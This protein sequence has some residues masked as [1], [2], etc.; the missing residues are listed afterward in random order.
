M[1]LTTSGTA[2]P[3]APPADQTVQPSSSSSGGIDFNAI[4]SG[5]ASPNASV[6]APNSPSIAGYSSIA[7][8]G[9]A[10]SAYQYQSYVANTAV[11]PGQVVAELLG[12]DPNKVYSGDQI[13]QA[14]EEAPHANL[15]QLQQYL[16]SAGMYASAA[17]TPTGTR[18]IFGQLNVDSFDAMS[19]LILQ[20]HNAAS[21]LS[22]S[23]VGKTI[24]ANTATMSDYIN[25]Q[26]NSGAGLLSIQGSL[27]PVP[28]GGNTYQVNLS[29]PN[30]IYQTAY[31][32]FEA[33]LGRAPTKTELDRLTTTLHTQETSYQQ[34]INTQAEN[35][36]QAKY[37][38]QIA[39]RQAEMTPVT[40]S[41]AI[42]NGPVNNPSDYAISL[43]SY[44]FGTRGVTASNVAM[45][46]SW[47]MA[48]GGLNAGGGMNPLGVKTNTPD[49]ATPNFT[50]WAQSIQAT[51]DLLSSPQYQ[52]I[53]DALNSGDASNQTG[54]VPFQQSVAQ[55]S[56][57]KVTGLTV[58]KAQTTAA[59]KAVKSYQT[60]NA[61]APAAS[62][63][64]ATGDLS[65]TA[66]PNYMGPLPGTSTTDLTRTQAPGYMGPLPSQTTPNQ[67]PQ[68]AI[69]ATLHAGATNPAVGAYLKEQ[70]AIANTL[71]M[72]ATDPAVGAY[73][74]AQQ[75]AQSPVNPSQLNPSQNLS[76]PGDFYLPSSTLTSTAAP[77]ASAAAF[78]QAT[79][80]SNAV[81]YLGNQY[82][83]AYNAILSMIKAGGPTG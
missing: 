19:Q 20:S 12:L 48:N 6:S 26:I 55:W 22:L 68:Q 8:P 59:T 9:A 32:V 60:S 18:P 65:R 21:T 82:L 74:K 25:N 56:G 70:Q 38:Q 53:F 40:A 13:M 41:G 35:M 5:V 64:P 79:T 16:Y 47:I 44:M 50:S 43:L 34:G 49:S 83:N 3:T 7:P 28:G 15:V 71:H 61:S 46:T 77:S 62:S 24:P 81:P 36:S 4:A 72:G 45:L 27:N 10:V 23:Q 80:G 42:P 76:S 69:E 30:D 78:T 52:A 51:A 63:T 29:N 37:N 1:S 54:N 75:A 73:L 67:T 33:A 11:A 58:T 57:G 14:Y 31:Q 39:A 66:A 2:A 17:G